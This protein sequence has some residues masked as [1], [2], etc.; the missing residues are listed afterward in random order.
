[1]RQDNPAARSRRT[2]EAPLDP[3]PARRP[4]Y[5]ALATLV[6]A[7]ALLATSLGT[8]AR[9][10][11]AAAPART[12]ASSATAYAPPLAGDPTVVHPFEEPVQV[13]AP[14]HRGVDLAA[15]AGAVVLA[16]AAGVISFAG[17]V[18][19]RGVVTV[20]HADG[21][22]SSLEPVD[23]QVSAGQRVEQGAALGTLSNPDPTRAPTPSHCAPA[24]CVH[25]GV[26]SGTRYRDPLSLLGEGGPVVLLP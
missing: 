25:W 18:A 14:G 20:T 7:G 8:S 23:P 26:R 3:H 17:Q 22:R 16:P 24:A 15:D 9:R 21:L 13:W 4:R 2:G 6:L 12:A 10:A 19:G 1:M 11:E 5:A